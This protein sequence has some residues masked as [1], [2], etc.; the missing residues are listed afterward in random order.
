MPSTPR[1][2]T[3]ERISQAKIMELIGM[4]D[5]VKDA[6][7]ARSHMAQTKIPTK[8]RNEKAIKQIFCKELNLYLADLS[9]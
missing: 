9:A 7:I 2:I 1:L 3:G 4:S 8:R 6:E 5:H